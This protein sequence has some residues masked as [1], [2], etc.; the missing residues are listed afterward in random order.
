[1]AQDKEDHQSSIDVVDE[2]GMVE[3]MM[4]IIMVIMKT[5]MLLINLYL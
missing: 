1:M 4:N 3:L 2:L 5:R